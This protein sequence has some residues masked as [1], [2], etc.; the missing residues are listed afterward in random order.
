MILDST[1][2]RMRASRSRNALNGD[3]AFPGALLNALTHGIDACLK[4][5]EFVI[6]LRCCYAGGELAAANPMNA[7]DCCIDPAQQG[8]TEQA[9][10]AGV[11]AQDEESDAADNLQEA[12]ALREDFF[13]LNRDD[14]P[15]IQSC[16]P[17]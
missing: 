6:N 2:Q 5:T 4:A 14:G 1:S 16:R 3:F 7:V 11:Q 9:D 12:V 8:A 10:C 15:A 17:W 13:F